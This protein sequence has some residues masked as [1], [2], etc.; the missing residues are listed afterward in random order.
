MFECKKNLYKNLQFVIYLLLL[1]AHLESENI[2]IVKRKDKN[3]KMKY[4]NV[5]KLKQ[6]RQ[7]P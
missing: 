2:K 3:I 6:N 1:E 4:A 7:L 5:L